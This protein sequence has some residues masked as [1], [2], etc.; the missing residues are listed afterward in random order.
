[1]NRRII[2]LQTE[3]NGFSFS[4]RIARYTARVASDSIS[5]SKHVSTR[6]KS[7]LYRRLY[8]RYIL[9][10]APEDKLQDVALCATR[11]CRRHNFR[12]SRQR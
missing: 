4:C 9:Y 11:A 10:T 2:E 5:S 12:L 3:R 6:N 7:V 1:M 8:H